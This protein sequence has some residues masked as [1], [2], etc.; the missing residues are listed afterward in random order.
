MGKKVFNNSCLIMEIA[1]YLWNKKSEN[2][3][4]TI[5]LVALDTI[6]DSKTSVFKS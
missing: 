2:Y 6:Y 5:I 1:D 4:N 3:C